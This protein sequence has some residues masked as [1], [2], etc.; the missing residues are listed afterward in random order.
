MRPRRRST[1]ELYRSSLWYTM[2]SYLYPLNPSP[3]P[4]VQVGCVPATLLYA[5]LSIPTSPEIVVISF[6]WEQTLT[7]THEL[8][9]RECEDSGRE[10][11]HAQYGLPGCSRI[12]TEVLVNI[13]TLCMFVPNCEQIITREKGRTPTI[14]FHRSTAGSS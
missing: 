8:I 1:T 6:V 11:N 5:C 2:A 3:P 7:A 12:E 10:D 13:F 4:R 9:V 14:T